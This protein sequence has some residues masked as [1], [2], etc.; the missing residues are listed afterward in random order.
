MADI[1][2][3]VR[4][5]P[6]RSADGPVRE[7]YAQSKREIG[8]LVEAVTM[9]S[10]DP[11]LLAASWAA[12]REPLLAD[13]AAP[14]AAKEAVAATVSRLNDCPYCVDAHAIMLYGSGAGAFATQLLSGGAVDAESTAGGELA[15][16]AAWAEAVS[17]GPARAP[18]D[19]VQAPEFVGVL[20]YFHFLNRV[21]NVL[22]AGTFLPG[23]PRAKAVARRIAGRGMARRITAPKQPGQAVGLRRGLPLPA[24]LAWAAGNGPVADAFASLAAETDAAAAR[25]VPAA[26]RDA[27]AR[28]LDGWRGD[29]PGISAAWVEEHL[30]DVP[31][32]ARPAARLALLTALA[33]YQ[34][35][36]DDVLA[37]TRTNPGERDLLGV[38]SWS[39]LAAARRIGS[40]STTNTTA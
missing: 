24:D 19:V 22:L 13:G 3:H 39:A 20:V 5:V 37:Y 18:F 11:P 12:F 21:I 28:V 7:V 31:P 26:A 33:P 1:V 40:W 32:G 25:C 36:D 15:P 10:V 16:V 35:S 23:P 34:V 38:L 14:R 9:F 30:A 2:K 4:V 8:R 17:R 29:S 6:P 27:L